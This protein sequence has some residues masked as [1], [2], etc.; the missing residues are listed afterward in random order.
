REIETVNDSCNATWDGAILIVKQH[1]YPSWAR[2]TDEDRKRA[3][4]TLVAFIS[5]SP[6]VPFSVLFQAKL[7]HSNW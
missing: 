4:Y 3:E 2:A 6:L 7:A 5:T 1:L